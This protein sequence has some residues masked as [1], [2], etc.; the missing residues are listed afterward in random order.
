MNLD[1]IIVLTTLPNQEQASSMAVALVKE[2][3]AACVQV[4]PA[5]QS[6]Y[7]WQG[8]LQQD[9]EFLLLIKS[10]KECYPALQERICQLHPYEIPE[11]LAT[12]VSDGLPA[13]LDWL[14]KATRSP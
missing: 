10:R 1:V 14:Q 11:I 4:L 6:F 12:S 7:I 5:M 2:S 13:Y 3:L 9:E 8:E